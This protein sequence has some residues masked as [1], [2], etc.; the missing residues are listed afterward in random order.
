MKDIINLLETAKKLF[1]IEVK[2]MVDDD[3]K[4]MIVRYF[5][6][7]HK[8]IM[9]CVKELSKDETEGRPL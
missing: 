1:K 3:R 8:E 7:Y 9:W 6:K 5:L 4:M 2:G